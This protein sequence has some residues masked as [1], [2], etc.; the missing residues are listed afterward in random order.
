MGKI[1]SSEEEKEEEGRRM[2]MYS[3]GCNVTH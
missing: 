3:R 1:V 2:S